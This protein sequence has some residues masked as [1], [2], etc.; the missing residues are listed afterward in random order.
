MNCD[1]VN[2]LLTAYLQHEVTITQEDAIQAHL[3]GCVDC[4]QILGDLAAVEDGLRQYIR[5][6]ADSIS[7]PELAWETLHTRLGQEGSRTKLLAS[8]D[9]RKRSFSS[10]WS[11][12]S[13]SYR[14]AVVLVVLLLLTLLAPPALV[15]AGRVREWLN[16]SYSFQVQDLGGS[17]GGFDAFIPYYPTYLP[18]GFNGLGIGGNTGPDWDQLELTFSRRDRFVTLLQSIG[19]KDNALPDGQVIFIQEQEGVYVPDFANSIDELRQ[20]F[21]GISI[22]TNFDYSG[23]DLLVWTMGGIR[24]ELITNLSFEEGLRFAQSLALMDRGQE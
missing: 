18:K 7:P 1:Q 16:P 23:L 24:M 22:T 8:T 11:D 5:T 4:R 10:R 13:L 14:W 21:P 2:M 6:K 3:A 19:L 17:I 12:R 15:L 20:E 9:R